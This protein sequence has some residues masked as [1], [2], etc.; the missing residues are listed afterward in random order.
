MF[1]LLS[2]QSWKSTDHDQTDTNALI[3]VTE[4]NQMHQLL[5][6][7][8]KGSQMLVISSNSQHIPHKCKL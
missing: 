7:N 1:Q 6:D 2:E 5:K 3:L 4:S 8:M